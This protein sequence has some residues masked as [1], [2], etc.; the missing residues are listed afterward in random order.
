VRPVVC[1]VPRNSYCRALL[2]VSAPSRTTF[3]RWVSNITK[4]LRRAENSVPVHAHTVP[5]VCA[6]V[7]LCT[8]TRPVPFKQFGIPL[9][10]S[11][12]RNDLETPVSCGRPLSDLYGVCS[13]VAPMSSCF[14]SVRTAFCRRFIVHMWPTGPDFP[15]KFTDASCA[16]NCV[17]GKFTT[18]LSAALYSGTTVHILLAQKDVLLTVYLAISIHTSALLR[19]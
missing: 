3:S 19:D 17:P 16:W 14:S 6:C 4:L 10:K 13:D 5:G 1:I 11:F 8:R 18:K 12:L 9:K 15:S 2:Y 7:S